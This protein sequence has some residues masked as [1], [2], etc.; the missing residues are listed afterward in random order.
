MSNFIEFIY[1]KCCNL[2]KLQERKKYK[3]MVKALALVALG[4]STIA[5][6]NIK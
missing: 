4:Q 1:L 3:K 6:T 5:K 2:R